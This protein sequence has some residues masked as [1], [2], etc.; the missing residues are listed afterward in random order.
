MNAL[1]LSLSLLAA[2]SPSVQGPGLAFLNGN[3]ELAL[4]GIVG[5]KLAASAQNLGRL[6]RV[7]SGQD[8]ADLLNVSQ[9]RCLVEAED[10]DCMIQLSETLK[11]RYVLVSDLRRL[12][13]RMVLN[14]RV[15][16][17][18]SGKAGLR[19]NREYLSEAVL[20]A[21]LPPLAKAAVGSLFGE[22]A[23]LTDTFKLE[24][25]RRRLRRISM[26]T[27]TLLS[28]AGVAMMVMAAA[29]QSAAQQNWD[30]EA[31]KSRSSLQALLDAESANQSQYL[32]GLGTGT[33]GIALGIGGWWLWR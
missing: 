13:D 3:P 8:M 6:S 24:L 2:E 21:D 15:L 14:L 12:E 9:T 16:D 17:T 27:G 4:S 19:L 33:V 20:L 23:V 22:A 1:L 25:G 5:E 7:V 11:V 10:S 28:V 29:A 31:N 30:Q 18:Q 26:G 32:M